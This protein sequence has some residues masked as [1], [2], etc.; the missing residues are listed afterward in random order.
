MKKLSF[1][2]ALSLVMFFIVGCGGN[3]KAEVSAEGEKLMKYAWKLQPNESLDATSDVVE[4]ETG[5]VADIELNGDVGDFADFL[6]ET[7]VFGRG[8]DASLLVYSST[9]GEGILSSEVTGLW[10]MPSDTEVVMKV[11]DSNLGD[12]AEG[13]AYKIVELTDDKLVL[14]NKETGGIKVYF[15]K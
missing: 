5:I 6:A 9:I 7:L 3:K 15:P 12:Y 2:F 13:V 8:K 4:D 10:S 1:L 14:E 11:W